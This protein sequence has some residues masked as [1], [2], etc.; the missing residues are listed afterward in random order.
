TACPLIAPVDCGVNLTNTFVAVRVAE[1]NATVAVLPQ[2]TSSADTSKLFEEALM[3]ILPG[4][5]VKSVPLKLKD[6]DGEL[7]PT[8][9][10]PKLTEVGAAVNAGVGTTVPHTETG[11]ELLRGLGKPVMKSALLSSVSVQP[12]LILKP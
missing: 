10:L 7:V 4:A 1:V 2:F 9:M 6:A 3:V 12:S 8:V 5:P 11:D